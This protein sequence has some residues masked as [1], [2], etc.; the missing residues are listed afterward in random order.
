MA[1]AHHVEQRPDDRG[2]GHHEH[3]AGHDRQGPG[4][5]E[6]QEA[7]GHRTCERDGDAHGHE[8]QD[9]P[10]R[11]AGQLAE[12]QVGGR[13][14]QQQPDQQ[15]DERAEQVAE[16]LLGLHQAQHVAGEQAGGKQQEQ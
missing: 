4:H 11:L 5:V 1:R 16:E 6:E 15:G 10:P 14:E 2:A 12:V 7:R 13:L 9:R 8:A 3:A